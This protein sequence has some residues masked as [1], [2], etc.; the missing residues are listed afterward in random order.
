MKKNKGNIPEIKPSKGFVTNPRLKFEIDSTK[1][2]SI[3]S[4]EGVF[5]TSDKLASIS[6]AALNIDDETNWIS[7]T[8]SFM[9]WLGNIIR[10]KKSSPEVL[11]ESLN[12]EIM[13]K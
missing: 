11:V 3:V 4:S 6:A 10:N 12:S 1:S 9:K 13:E 8:L 5:R 2:G 7:S